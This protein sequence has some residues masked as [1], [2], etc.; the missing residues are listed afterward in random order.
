M[1]ESSDAIAQEFLRIGIHNET[2]RRCHRRR[3]HRS[4]SSLRGE[5][6]VSDEEVQA[7]K[8]VMKAVVDT[9]EKAE[10]PEKLGHR[11]RKGPRQPSGLYPADSQQITRTRHC[12][13]TQHD[14][15]APS[16]RPRRL[17]GVSGS[18]LGVSTCSEDN[19]TKSSRASSPLGDR[20]VTND[21]STLVRSASVPA[22][23]RSPSRSMNPISVWTQQQQADVGKVAPP[24]EV[25]VGWD[26]RAELIRETSRLFD[27]EAEVIEALLDGW[28]SEEG[29][30]FGVDAAFSWLLDH[31][32]LALSTSRSPRV[33]SI[34]SSSSS[35]AFLRVCVPSTDRR[36]FSLGLLS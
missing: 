23:S 33:P 30:R 13:P 16:I 18:H 4:G 27:L 28:Y 31:G 6:L 35:R 34:C 22:N 2:P 36:S 25:V 3:H 7:L 26:Q 21:L 9:E 17:R 5:H 12:L 19:L 14:L 20:A 32:G 1:S 29:K 11:L 24:N 10:R 15:Q 8:A